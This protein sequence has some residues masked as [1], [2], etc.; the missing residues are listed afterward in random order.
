M[1]KGSLQ[2]SFNAYH[3]LFYYFTHVSYEN[4]FSRKKSYLHYDT[5]IA[6]QLTQPRDW[7]GCLGKHRISIWMGLSYAWVPW[8]VTSEE[9]FPGFNIINKGCPD[10]GD[11][12]Q[13]ELLNE[14]DM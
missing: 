3:L 10:Q 8:D 9:V 2:D 7:Q 13:R 6:E 5:P 12:S 11:R 1:S 14:S 4:A